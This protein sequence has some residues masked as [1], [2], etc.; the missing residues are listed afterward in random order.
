[1]DKNLK[2]LFEKELTPQVN[3]HKILMQKA[4]QAEKEGNLEDAILYLESALLANPENKTAK[5]KLKLF[6]QSIGQRYLHLSAATHNP[7]SLKDA[8]T[9]MFKSLLHSAQQLYSSGPYNPQLRGIHVVAT[10]RRLGDI[11]LNESVQ[12]PNW[13]LVSEGKQAVQLKFGNYIIQ[14]IKLTKQ[15][16]W[17]FTAYCDESNVGIESII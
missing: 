7:E 5:E 14:A 9:D 11:K 15:K 17:I 13:S 12:K 6:E 2:K 4:E 3:P 16:K 10:D 1:M 8:I